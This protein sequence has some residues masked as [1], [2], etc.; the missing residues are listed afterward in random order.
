MYKI[1]SG[2]SSRSETGEGVKWL[3]EQLMGARKALQKFSGES[4]VAVIGNTKSGKSTGV[5]GLIGNR[6]AYRK[7]ERRSRR[8]VSQGERRVGRSVPYIEI[9]EER[10]LGPEIGQNM[11]ACTTF[12]SLYEMSN[13]MQVGDFAGFYGNRGLLTSIVEGV[14]TQMAFRNGGE[15]SGVVL[16]VP[17]QAFSGQGGRL[18]VDAF[19]NLNRLLDDPMRHKESIG[20]AIT[21]TLDQKVK[22]K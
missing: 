19:R 3:I 13:K 12:P 7:P 16:F 15:V 21:H 1:I 2:Y 14:S 5:H 18:V 20:F 10:I 6:L 17:Y 22:K 11:R 8:E 9:V 4:F